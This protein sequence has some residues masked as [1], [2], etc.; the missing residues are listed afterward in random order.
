MLKIT[1]TAACILVLTAAAEA[2]EVLSFPSTDMVIRAGID[3]SPAPKAP[4]SDRWTGAYAGLAVGYGMLWD[5]QN[6]TANGADF[7]GFAGYNIRIK[8]PIIGGLEGE[9]MHIG[10]E[11]NDNI[12]VI[13]NETFTAKVRVGYEH[14]R[15]LAYAL[16]GAQH[17]TSKVPFPWVPGFRSVDTTYVL[18]AGADVAVTDK[19]SLGAEYTRAFYT[20]FDKQTLGFPLDVRVQRVN[21]RLTYKIN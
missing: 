10:R 17:A 21:A 16:A 6:A 4:S 19:I 18:G 2:N 11:F 3:E 15:F 5:S 13:A 20:D 1:A 8:G 14:G 7:G 12:G 9:Y